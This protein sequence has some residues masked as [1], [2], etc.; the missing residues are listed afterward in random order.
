MASMVYGKVP[1]Q[2]K[3]LEENV[4][5]SILN[6]R[7]AVDIAVEILKPEHFYLEIHQVIFEAILNLYR[8]SVMVEIPS[9]AHELKRMGKLEDI[10]GPY[11]L[12]VISNKSTSWTNVEPYSRIIV[13]KYM[14]REMIRISG[15]TITEAYDETADV[16]ETLSDHD[17]KFTSLISGT[18]KTTFQ[19]N[20]SALVKSIH[21]IEELRKLPD[22][23]TG[24]ASGF[25]SLDRVTHGWQNTD[26]IIIA[27]R[28]SVGKTAFALNLARNAAKHLKRPVPVAFFSL[29]MSTGQIMNRI[30]AAES[31]IWLD[32][33]LSGRLSNEEMS[34]IGQAAGRFSKAPIWWDDTAAMNLHEMRA[35]ARRLKNK[36]SIGMIIIDYLQLMSGMN[37]RGQN[38]EQEI[39]TISRGLKQLA[40]ELEVPIIALSQLSRAVETR[41]GDKKMPQLS[42]LRESGAIEQDA[43]MVMF[44]YRPEYYDINADGL[45]EST[46]GETHVKIAKHRNGSLETIK[47]RANLGIQ[48]FYEMDDSSAPFIGPA[49][50]IFK[51]VKIDNEQF[52]GF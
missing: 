12:T 6:E 36:H 34:V 48:K 5:G 3:D 4:L 31:D 33:I 30:L 44:L 28:P 47:L 22:H 35:K 13:Q 29:E 17:K 49:G 2:A 10:G 50:Q 16:F 39:S 24:I 43:D 23:I 19:S 15:E 21:R 14:Q 40:K 7:P 8:S 11:H 27:A 45:G 1:P 42:D 37:E 46:K 38:R 9:V 41:T 25:N 32:K 26:L 20:D 52:E 18:L 51:P